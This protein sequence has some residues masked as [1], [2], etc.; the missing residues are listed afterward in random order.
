MPRFAEDPTTGSSGVHVHSVGNRILFYGYIEEDSTSELVYLLNE[1][2]DSHPALPYTL[3][4]NSNGGGATDGLCIY[5]VISSLKNLEL[6]SCIDSA[7]YSASVLIHLACKR[8]YMYKS[9][10]MLIHQIRGQYQEGQE[11]KFK[12]IVD[13][14]EFMRTL[15]ELYMEIIV[16]HSKMSK[17]VVQDLISKERLLTAKECMKLGLVDEVI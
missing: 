11:Y 17:K 2:D 10:T 14:Q 1:L 3:H 5:N 13:E 12:D 8:R 4:I 16:R 7:C 6:H 15:T 9:S